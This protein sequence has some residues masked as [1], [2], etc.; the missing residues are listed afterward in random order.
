MPS[1]VRI[2]SALQDN[3]IYILVDENAKTALAIDPGEAQPVFEFLKS[4]SLELKDILLTHH[5]ADH[6]G[7]VDKL[8]LHTR[9]RV[10]GAR[11]D[12]HR[13]PPLNQE[14]A[15]GDVITFG[16][17][18][19]QV[20]E[21]PGHTLGA[22]AFY[23]SE[24]KI[25][26]TGDTLFSLGCG[27]VFEGSY[28]MMFES[29]KKL[30][31]LPKETQIYFGHEYTEKNCRFLISIPKFS[32]RGE[33]L[34]PNI[35]ALRSRGEFSSPNRLEYELENNPFLS[36]SFEEFCEMRELRNIF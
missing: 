18:R 16:D 29:L 21:V 5:H 12:K 13:L 2:L 30:K 28:E 26:F 8:V 17:F 4:S 35:Q 23:D 15:E 36:D 3:F 34:L 27:R 10:L 11:R 9:C 24:K 7:G 19:L 6:T 31:A 22:L 32:R 20:L 33:A 25:V 1:S 14:L